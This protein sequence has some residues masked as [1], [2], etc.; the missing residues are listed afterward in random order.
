MPNKTG[1]AEGYVHGFSSEEQKRLYEQGRFFENSVFKNVDFSKTKK[2][3]EIGSGVGA[4]TEILLERFPQL[5]IQCIDASSEQIETAKKNLSRR[6][7][8]QGRYHLEQADA[9]K[10]PYQDSTFEGAFICWLLEHVQ[11]PVE[12]LKEA[13][14]VL[15]QNGI[16]F[17]NEVL[18]ATFYMHPYSPA[19]QKFWFEF[20][21]HQ[22][23]LKGDPFVGG[24][25]ANYLLQAGFQEIT[26]SV[27]THHY[28]HRTPKKR[29]AFLEYWCSLLLSG[30]PA[31][32]KAGKINQTE[33]DEMT[34]E[35]SRLKNDPNSVIFYSWIQAQAKA[36]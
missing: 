19:T 13:H 32:I 29:A 36:L 9:L 11:N 1:I 4:Q 33:V 27:I 30:A 23:N 5:Q 7:E 28:D 25:L 6:K 34:S 8:F 22:W 20:N 14:R 2:I 21:D 10:L 26:T 3:I 31:L 18:N 12:I 24:K 16:I 35:F 17:C 15:K